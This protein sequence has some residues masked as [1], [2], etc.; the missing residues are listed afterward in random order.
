MPPKAS[1]VPSRDTLRVL[2][3][4]ALAGSAIGAFGGTAVLSADIYCRIR[5]AEQVLENA[6]ILKACQCR[7]YHSDAD[8]SNSKKKE[9]NSHWSPYSIYPESN[10]IGDGIDVLPSTVEK[11]YASIKGERSRRLPTLDSV[12]N[13]AD[14]STTKRPRVLDAESS[15]HTVQPFSSSDGKSPN[16]KSSLPLQ[17]T[18]SPPYYNPLLI[19]DSSIPP[20]L[21]ARFDDEGNILLERRWK[22]SSFAGSKCPHDMNPMQVMEKARNLSE[23]LRKRP[24]AELDPSWIIGLPSALISI[25][26]LN[27]RRLLKTLLR[28]GRMDPAQLGTFILHNYR[29]SPLVT[30]MCA[31]FYLAYGAT[32][33]FTIPNQDKMLVNMMKAFTSNGHFKAAQTLLYSLPGNLQGVRDARSIQVACAAH[34]LS[35]LFKASQSLQ[36]IN[37]HFEKIR[38]WEN[39][40]F[41]AC[42]LLVVMAQ[43]SIDSGRYAEVEKYIQLAKTYGIEESL[44]MH[45]TKLFSFAVREKWNIVESELRDLGVNRK[46][47]SNKSVQMG[48][49]K[50]LVEYRN[51]HTYQEI[52]GFFH[53][54]IKSHQIVPDRLISQELI[55]ILVE[56]GELDGVEQWLQYIKDRGLENPMTILF[57]DRLIR[58]FS[59]NNSVTDTSLEKL[60]YFFSYGFSEDNDSA[61]SYIAEKFKEHAARRKLS[62]SLSPTQRRKL[63]AVKV[64]KKYNRLRYRM[65]PPDLI[66]RR[67]LTAMANNR[68]GK[69]VKAFKRAKN[70]N[71]KL[72]GDHLE[73]AV[74]AS[75][76]YRQDIEESIQLITEARNVGIPSDTAIIAL[77]VRTVNNAIRRSSYSQQLR[78]DARNKIF[79]LYE[80]LAQHDLP[81]KHYVVVSIAARYIAQKRKGAAAIGILA[82][83]ANS[84][85]A[86]DSFFSIETLTVFIKGYAIIGDLEGLQWTLKM[87][88]RQKLKVD[89]V[90]YETLRYAKYPLLV[91][92][93][94]SLQ[95]RGLDHMVD[96]DQMKAMNI[97]ETWK[98]NIRTRY[99]A[100]SQEEFS[101]GKAIARFAMKFIEPEKLEPMVCGKLEQAGTGLWL[102]REIEGDTMDDI[103][104]YQSFPAID[105]KGQQSSQVQASISHSFEV[106]TQPYLQTQ[107][108][109]QPQSQS[110]PQPQTSITARTP[111]NP[112]NAMSPI[113]STTTGIQA[114]PIY[115]EAGKPDPLAATTLELEPQY[116]NPK[117]EDVEFKSESNDNSTTIKVE[118]TEH[119]QEMT[120]SL[121]TTPTKIKSQTG[122]DIMS[123]ISGYKFYRATA[124]QDKSNLKPFKSLQTPHHPKEVLG[125]NDVFM[126]PGDPKLKNTIYDLKDMLHPTNAEPELT[127][128]WNTWAHTPYRTKGKTFLEYKKYVPPTPA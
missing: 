95:A 22:I 6:K 14:T 94:R 38:E 115:P 39:G 5:L 112:R 116:N 19:R 113:D 21:E 72:T 70:R 4:L 43:A 124:V 60:S 98:E 58:R 51:Q 111:S 45:M 92:R 53:R 73:F 17:R 101:R 82:D 16:N 12:E 66:L 40:T 127:I 77:L 7:K 107:A 2:R 71:M 61:R 96:E 105:S 128:P 90:F 8:A 106:G 44:G 125:L 74:R 103:Q 27:T 26:L 31:R 121:E 37:G 63:T 3:H 109:L 78:E 117:N 126:K 97:M 10:V 24:M 59:S 100:D 118:T 30:E 81:I 68:P 67:I 52:L 91:T 29:K 85:W 64:K 11:A 9:S 47:G 114:G 86:N 28:S 120:Q 46:K 119:L 13:G 62:K 42:E 104:K 75:L 88:D 20:H 25:D 108:Q 54:S 79:K 48:F 80:F 87:V 15:D 33:D 18:W 93:R 123:K 110:Q 49:H 57:V 89:K 65:T 122:D 56:N 76:R 23:L 69:A 36:L 35:A 34:F 55:L 83:I 102:K 84:K 1:I 41:M 50:I 99:L 32:F